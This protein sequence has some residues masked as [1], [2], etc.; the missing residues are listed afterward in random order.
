MKLHSTDASV[1]PKNTQHTG[2]IATKEEINRICQ[3]IPHIEEGKSEEE[4]K[5]QG[6]KGKEEVQSHI[7]DECDS[8]KVWLIRFYTILFLQ[9]SKI[10]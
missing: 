10:E 4:C 1:W 5:V 6:V 8:Q 2:A 9:S 7:Q 3:V